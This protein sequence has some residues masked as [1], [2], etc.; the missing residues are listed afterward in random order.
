MQFHWCDWCNTVWK[1]PATQIFREINIRDL[2]GPKTA[3]LTHLEAMNF[4]FLSIF[5]FSEGWNLPKT[6]I[7]RPWNCKNGIFLNFYIIENW[8]HVNSEWYKNA[9]FSTLCVALLSW[10]DCLDLDHCMDASV[11]WR[12]ESVVMKCRNNLLEKSSNNHNLHSAREKN[13]TSF[14]G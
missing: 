4:D 1:F 8:F 3:I 7:Q 9:D 11:W 2:K 14:K 5:V 13:Q 6:K 10:K 12:E